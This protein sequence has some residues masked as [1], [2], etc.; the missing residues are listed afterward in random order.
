MRLRYSQLTKATVGDVV[1]LPG[2]LELAGKEFS[3]D[4]GQVATWRENMLA[5]GL[6]GVVAYE[7]GCPRG[8]AEFLPVETAP[9]PIVAPGAAVLLCY[10]WAGTRAEDPEHLTQE[11][12]LVRE[13]LRSADSA[14]FSGMATLGWDHPTHFP[15]S[16]LGELGF[17][18]VAREQSIALM[19]KP[20]HASAPIPRLAQVNHSAAD[21]SRE[22][23]LAVDVG[24]STRCP[25]SIH[26]T[27]RLEGM[28]K[29]H[30]CREHIRY[31]A[32]VIDTRVQALTVRPSPCDWWWVRFNGEMIDYFLSREK[33]KEEIARH[34]T[35]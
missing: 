8:F 7:G 4:I 9:A 6:Q 3:G 1:C 31:T 12:R 21:L 25:Y 14:G 29:A 27:T 13:T 33:L 30:P 20:F 22:G 19:W 10:H 26:H 5:R 23:L 16:L 34:L 17:A 2:K 32:H 24:Y 18:E 35:R 28:L 11:K 15:I